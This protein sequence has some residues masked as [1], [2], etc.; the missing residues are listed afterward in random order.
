[1][2]SKPSLHDGKDYTKSI[3]GHQIT[4]IAEL[5]PAKTKYAI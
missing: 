5:E 2:K 3:G 4:E 1:M